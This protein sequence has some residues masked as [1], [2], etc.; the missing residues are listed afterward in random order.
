M[1]IELIECC[2]FWSTL[3]VVGAD[4]G[5]GGRDSSRAAPNDEDGLNGFM[6]LKPVLC[7]CKGEIGEAVL[8]APVGWL[9]NEENSEFDVAVD[10]VA[11]GD[12]ARWKEEENE[13]KLVLPAGPTLWELLLL[14]IANSEATLA[15]MDPLVPPAEPKPVMF[16]FSPVGEAAPLV[17]CCC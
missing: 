2:L 8:V 15:I 6:P 10:P 9:D 13:G 5:I 4:W 11:V 12:A 14:G 3:G 16:G 1:P 7:G 17:C